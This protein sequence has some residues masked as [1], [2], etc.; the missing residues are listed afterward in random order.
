MRLKVLKL[1][2]SLLIITC[3]ISQAECQLID[4]RGPDRTGVYNETG[5]LQ[6]WPENGPELLWFVEDIGFGYSSPTI[7]NDAIYITGRKNKDD[8]LSAY[9]LEGKN[10]CDLIYGKAWTRNHQGT[11][12]TPTFVDGNIFLISGSGDIV[13]VNSNGEINWSKNH[14]EEYESSPQMFGISESPL[15]VDNKI[16]TSPGGNKASLVA[17][18]AENGTVE[19]EAE[20]LNEGPQYVNPLLVKI[21]GEK[22]IVTN[23]SSFIIGVDSE[24]GNILWKV[25][26]NELNAAEGRSR[27]NHT[28]TPL[29]K[30]GKILIANGYNFVAVQLEL[31]NDGSKVE[32]G[33]LNRD[34]DPHHGGLVLHGDYVYGSNY[35]NNAMGDWICVDWNTGETQWTERWYNKGSIISAD[36][37]LYI[38]EEKSGNLALVKPNPDKLD[39]VSEFKINKGEGPYWSHPVIDDGKLYVRHGEV[40]MVYAIK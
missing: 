35:L 16:I 33:W 34:I 25:N 7:T 12:C 10:K 3:F 11:R 13:C 18:N 23:T 31:S 38:Y 26:Y 39:I 27:R 20:S 5:L 32:V 40:L 21:G 1:S 8:F 29:F 22:I 19:W 17:Y 9:T 15:Y 4:W 37:M 28:T 24:N 14:Y 30:D 6:K 2:L 36:G